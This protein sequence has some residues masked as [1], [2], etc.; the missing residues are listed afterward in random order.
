MIYLRLDHHLISM[1]LEK[2]RLMRKYILMGPEGA[3]GHGSKPDQQ[4]DSDPM[5][6]GGMV[7]AVPGS[8]APLNAD[9]AP[10]SASREG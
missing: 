1:I 9:K 5:L 4:T 6:G 10:Q 3:L 8:A 7:G 2:K